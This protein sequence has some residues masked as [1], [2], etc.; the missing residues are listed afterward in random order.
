MHGWAI[1][2]RMRIL[3]Y[4]KEECK[5]KQTCHGGLEFIEMI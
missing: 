5:R 2:I 3:L 1:I 4:P